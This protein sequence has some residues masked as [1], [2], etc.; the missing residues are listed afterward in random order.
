MDLQIR[1][2]I[3]NEALG[4]EYDAFVYDILQWK[5]INRELNFEDN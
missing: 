1:I 4:V 5:V 2:S 3:I